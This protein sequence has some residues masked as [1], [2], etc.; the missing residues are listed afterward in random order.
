MV[1]HCYID[2]SKT[3]SQEGFHDVY[4]EALMPNLGNRQSQDTGS[5]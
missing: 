1:K 2:R 4:T 3:V 5:P